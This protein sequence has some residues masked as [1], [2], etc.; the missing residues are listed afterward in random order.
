[1]IVVNELT[2]SFIVLPVCEEKSEKVSPRPVCEGRCLRGWPQN[3]TLGVRLDPI[4]IPRPS[5]ECQAEPP[6][7]PAGCARLG[8]LLAASTTISPTHG[9]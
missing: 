1:M 2:L 9:Q 4:P 7:N 8:Q 6:E 5:T 3:T